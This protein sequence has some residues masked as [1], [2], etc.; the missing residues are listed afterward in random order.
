HGRPRGPRARHHHDLVRV[1]RGARDERPHRGDA[2]RH[3]HRRARPV[4]GDAGEGAR[5]R[6]RRWGG[7]AGVARHLREVSVLAAWLGLLLV[8][9]AAPVPEK[10]WAAFG[11]SGFFGWSEIRNNLVKCAPVLVAAVGM[12]LVIL[13]RQIDISIGA[14]MAVCAVAA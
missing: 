9:A 11:S 4:G 8:I 12:T 14:Q 2:R 7:G 6:D 3:D 1:A 10:G 13:A 5:T